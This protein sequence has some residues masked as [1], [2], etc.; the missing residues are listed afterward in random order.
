M[1]RPE[2]KVTVDSLQEVVYEKSIGTEMNDLDLCFERGVLR[3]CQPLR[4]SRHYSTTGIRK[5]LVI[6]AWF[7]R[8]TIGNGYGS[9]SNDHVI[10]H[11]T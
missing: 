4:H 6:D 3:A 8:T 10:D 11:V 2:A 7:Q 5:T 1:V 9:L